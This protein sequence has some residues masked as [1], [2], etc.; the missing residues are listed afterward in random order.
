MRIIQTRATEMARE[1][2][3]IGVDLDGTLA[4]YHGWQGADH[5][6]EPVPTML[7]RVRKW[8]ASGQRVKIFTARADDKVAVKA[9]TE[10]LVKHGIGGLEITNV[11]DY[12]MT[13]LWDDRAIQVVENTGMPIEEF[14]KNG[15]Q[16]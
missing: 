16:L 10:W 14:L 13:Q 1:L 2:G 7:F 8:I 4:K 3:W 5:I 9:I 6:G 11:K 12:A 15:G